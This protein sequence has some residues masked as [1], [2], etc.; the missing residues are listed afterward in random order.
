[1]FNCIARKVADI[2][3]S[4]IAFALAFSLIL[5]WIVISGVFFAFSAESQIPIN[6]ITTIVTFLVVFLIQNTQ[7]NDTDAI[8]AKLDEI[9]RAIEDADD[10]LIAVEQHPQDLPRIRDDHAST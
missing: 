1:M 7:N 6:T 3:G 8:H 5:G 10:R 4:W 9:V 2:I